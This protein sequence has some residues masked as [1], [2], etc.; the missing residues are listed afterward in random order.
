MNDVITLKVFMGLDIEIEL[1]KLQKFIPSKASKFEI[2]LGIQEIIKN[3]L[4]AE[5]NPNVTA[6]GPTVIRF[7]D[8][9]NDMEHFTDVLDSN[10]RTIHNL[11]SINNDLYPVLQHLS[12]CD[13]MIE[14][15]DPEDPYMVSLS[16]QERR[17]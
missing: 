6:P 8:I 10:S 5:A 2:L 16:E 11:N 13:A 9:H 3:E 17:V 14:I 7:Y 12:E 4:A 15:E 1:S